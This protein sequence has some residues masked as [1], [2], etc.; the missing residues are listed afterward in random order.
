MRL[1]DLSTRLGNYVS[2]LIYFRL[3]SNVH[4]LRFASG[5]H[6]CPSLL[7]VRLEQSDDRVIA[8][9]QASQLE[10]SVTAGV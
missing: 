4:G 9:G 3:E 1:L 7:A 2:S 8:P 10:F 5:S 6:H